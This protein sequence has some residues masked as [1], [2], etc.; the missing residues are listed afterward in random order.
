MSFNHYNTIIIIEKSA[1]MDRYSY[2]TFNGYSRIFI[3]YA[4]WFYS[5]A[6]QLSLISFHDFLSFRVKRTRPN[7][8]TRR[9]GPTS[10]TDKTVYG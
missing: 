4:A 2:E 5:E 1:N 8:G 3:N 6:L 9:R 10:G 7:P